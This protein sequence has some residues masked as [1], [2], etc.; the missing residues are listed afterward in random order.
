MA[1]L[2]RSAAFNDR[3]VTVETT[4]RRPSTKYEP[5]RMEQLRTALTV[6]GKAN[7]DADTAQC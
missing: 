6:L 2:L 3:A 1:C 5:S 7:G 4:A